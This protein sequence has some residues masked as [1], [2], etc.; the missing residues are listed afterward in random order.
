MAFPLISSKLILISIL[1]T[2]TLPK[3]LT[4]LLEGFVRSVKIPFSGYPS[5]C[6]YSFY[7]IIATALGEEFQ[8][9]SAVI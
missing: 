9:R 6:P 8:T 2:N 7:H 4:K 5:K 1:S 3:L